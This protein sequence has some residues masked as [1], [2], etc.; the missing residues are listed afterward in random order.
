MGERISMRRKAR[1]AVRAFLWGVFLFLGCGGEPRD[2]AEFRARPGDLEAASRQPCLQRDPLRRALFGD[3]HVHTALSSDAWNYDVEVRPSDAYAYA[4]GEPILLPPKDA[5]GAGTRRVRIDRPLDFAAVTD[6]AEFLGE[7]RLCADPSSEAYASETCVEV[8]ASTTPLDN[9]FVFVS[10]NPW[11]SRADDVCGEDGERCREALRSAW[12]ETIRAAQE[13]DDSSAAC[14]RTTFI[15][16]EY[17]SLRLGSN[18]H[19]NV[20]FRN[21]VVPRRPFSYLDA[22]RAWQLWEHLRDDC[23]ESGTGCDA[24]SIPHNSNISNGRMFAVDYPETADFEAEVARA[25]LRA[26]V[27]PLVEVMQHKGDSECRVEMDGILGATDEA[28]GFEK[29]SAV[30]YQDEDGK[31]GA[32]GACWD[33]M[34]DSLPHLGPGACMNHRNYVRYV[35]TEGL[36]EWERL[37]VNPTKLGIL[38]STDTHNGMA[39]GVDERTF[40][41]HVGII[42]DEAQRRVS[43]ETGMGNMANNPGGLVGVWAEE[44]SRDAIFDAMQR[45]EVFGT[46][47]PR[48]RPRFFGGFD[49]PEDLCDAPNP[50]ARADTRG[51]PMGGDLSAPPPGATPAFWVS[52]LADAGTVERSG[53][54]LERIQ[55][56]KGWVDEGGQLH[57]R[58]VD[59]AG[60]DNGASVDPLTCEPQGEGARRL[61]G[62]WRDPDFDASRPAVYYARVLENPS[63]RHSAWACLE[64]PASERPPGCEHR[65]MERFVKER[66]WTSPIWFTPERTGLD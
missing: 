37:G 23:I 50:V 58:V 28:C 10:M 22:Q 54:D 32:P 38:A 5:E 61:C 35:L 39:G 6:H 34:A 40:P 13:W 12:D 41:G 52:A 8:R 4:F 43:E 36:R 20:I 51:V 60:G 47:G 21:E 29:F 57:Q 31:A 30:R 11:P 26:R 46:S 9:P 63:C 53:G 64:W 49:L 24:I 14:E 15:G 48:I 62:V 3:L 27:E 1:G 66:A 42:D 44:N 45:R 19:R 2:A 17:S 18:L 16:Y 33:W 25:R 59:V 65:A 7:T 56:V 55:I